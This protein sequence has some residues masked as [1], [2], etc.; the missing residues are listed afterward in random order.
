MLNQPSEMMTRFHV[1][2]MIGQHLTVAAQNPTNHKN[3]KNRQ[4]SRIFCESPSVRPVQ[5]S[6]Q[7]GHFCI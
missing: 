5:A 1:I 4:T 6:P 2:F 7:T 3:I